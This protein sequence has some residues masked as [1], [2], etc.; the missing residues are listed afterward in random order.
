MDDEYDEYNHTGL[1]KDGYPI[2]YIW[3][4][5]DLQNPKQTGHYKSKHYGIDHNQYVLNGYT[6]QS[7]YGTGFHVLDVSSIPTDPTGKGVEE[8][9]FFD[10]YP[11]DDNEPNGGVIDFAGTWSSYAMFKSGFIFVNTIERGGFVVK[12]QDNVLRN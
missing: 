5:K 3:D 2:T 10:V 6:Y 4:I 9:G 8:V 11:E 7:N 12:V 1:A